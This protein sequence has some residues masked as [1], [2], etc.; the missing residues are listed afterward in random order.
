[1]IH[2]IHMLCYIILWAPLSWHKHGGCW[3]PGDYLTADNQQP[4]CWSMAMGI[5]GLILGLRPAN[6]RRRYF[7][8]TS[9]IGWAQT[10]ISPQ[11]SS[12]QLELSQY[13]DAVLTHLPL[14]KKAAI[15][16]TFSNTFSWMKK[17]K[18]RLSFH[19]SLLPRVQLTIIQHWFK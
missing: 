1:M 9:L 18:F 10:R 6:E 14:D 8:T 7:L 12:K 15:S 11:V 17:Y 4:P 5:T 3:W 19:W 13:K 16:Q 2:K